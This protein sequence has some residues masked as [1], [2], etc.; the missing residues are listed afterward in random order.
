MATF[1][2]RRNHQ[3]IKDQDLHIGNLLVEHTLGVHWTTQNHYLGFK[4]NLK[5]K[6]LTRRGMFSTISLV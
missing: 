1:R 2:K 5:Y 4:I 3:K 6:Q